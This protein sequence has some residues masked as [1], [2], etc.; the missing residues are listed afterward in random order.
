[1]SAAEKTIETDAELLAHVIAGLDA[2]PTAG[3]LPQRENEWAQLERAIDAT[4]QVPRY[5][6]VFVC[7]SPGTGKTATLVSV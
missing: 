2:E 7:G 6:S 4:L 3:P 5:S 1:M